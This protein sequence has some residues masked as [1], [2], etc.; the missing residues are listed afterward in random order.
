ML[1]LLKQMEGM[2]TAK[3]NA[4]YLATDA[5]ADQLIRWQD[6]LTEPC[7]FLAPEGAN[8]AI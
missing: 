1:S 4:P 5:E 2:A 8:N 6:R 3:A 7:C